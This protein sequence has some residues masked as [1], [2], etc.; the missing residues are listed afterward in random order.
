MEKV[1]AE[2]LRTK[3]QLEQEFNQKRAKFKEL[4]LAKEGKFSILWIVLKFM[5]LH[6]Q[7]IPVWRITFVMPTT[8]AHVLFLKGNW[9]LKGFSPGVVECISSMVS[10]TKHY[11]CCVGLPETEKRQDSFE[12]IQWEQQWDNRGKCSRWL[13]SSLELIF[14]IKCRD[15]SAWTGVSRAAWCP[16]RN[17]TPEFI[18]DSLKSWCVRSLWTAA[19]LVSGQSLSGCCAVCTWWLLFYAASVCLRFPSE[20]ERKQTNIIKV[21]IPAKGTYFNN[22]L[23][24]KIWT[25]WAQIS[26]EQLQSRDSCC[27]E[28]QIDFF[29]NPDDF[30]VLNVGKQSQK[31]MHQDCICLYKFMRAEIQQA[32]EDQITQKAYFFLFLVAGWK[33]IYDIRHYWWDQQ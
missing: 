25:I 4:Y 13:F 31:I 24:R 9:D 14:R 3:Q 27:S 28:S 12:Q 23:Y 7:V 10:G 18:T 5:E 17:T 32:Y 8:T 22:T 26:D 33:E 2:F 1:N 20:V 16:L 11:C 6:L 21:L 15:L 30:P 29:S 19:S